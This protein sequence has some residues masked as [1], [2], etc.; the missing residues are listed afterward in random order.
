MKPVSSY[1]CTVAPVAIS[2]ASAVSLALSLVPVTSLYTTCSVSLRPQLTTPF[3]TTGFSVSVSVTVSL[4]KIPVTFPLSVS[5]KVC[6][7]NTRPNPSAP[8]NTPLPMYTVTLTVSFICGFRFSSVSCASTYIRS[9]VWY[10]ST[11]SVN[12]VSS[13]SFTRLG[14]PISSA[15]AVSPVVSALFTSP[16]RT[17]IVSLFPQLTTPSP[18]VGAVVSVTTTVSLRNV[19]LTSPLSVS[20][21]VSVSST[22]PAA[23]AP[24]AYPFPTYTTTVTVSFNCGFRFSSVSITWMYITSRVNSVSTSS[25]YPLSSKICVTLPSARSTINAVSLRT[26]LTSFVSVYVTCSVSPNPAT[27]RPFELISG[28]SVSTNATP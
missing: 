11:S 22:S 28:F 8:S 24:S 4:R 23:L 12:T 17:Y 20:S 5:T 1:N 16:Y 2:I 21:T 27:S 26:S 10:V 25:A 9:L 18:A 19:R 6:V 7:Y 14:V 13:Y 3:S 15:S